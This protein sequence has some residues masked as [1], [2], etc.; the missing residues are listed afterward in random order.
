MQITYL[1]QYIVPKHLLYVILYNSKIVKRETHRED[2]RKPES[3][4]GQVYCFYI[5]YTKIDIKVVRCK[6]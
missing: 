2:M 4:T 6:A 1:I 5:A 3:A